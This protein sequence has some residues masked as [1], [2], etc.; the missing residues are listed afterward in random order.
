VVAVGPGETDRHGNLVPLTIVPNDIVV[1]LAEAGE[2][3]KFAGPG[4][5]MVTVQDV[6]AVIDESDEV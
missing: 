6:I 2:E 4:L 3:M 1:V 5:F